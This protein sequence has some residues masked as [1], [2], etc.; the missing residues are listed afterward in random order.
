M[1][2]LQLFSPSSPVELD[3]TSLADP[4]WDLRG[5]GSVRTSA[6]LM[7]VNSV[8]QSGYLRSRGAWEAAVQLQAQAQGAKE[9][10]SGLP[11]VILNLH[12][13]MIS[14]LQLHGCLSSRLAFQLS[15]HWLP[16]KHTL[17]S[18]W[19]IRTLLCACFALL[20]HQCFSWLFSLANDFQMTT[21]DRSL[22][23]C[24]KVG[25]INC[26]KPA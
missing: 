18:S 12:L 24:C 16:V 2:H 9:V 14:Q 23:G 20:S 25:G 6:L 4:S 11:A 10:C 13:P 15:S 1:Q 17:K 5:S 19:L 21:E 22:P 7:S 26:Q 8:N 3:V